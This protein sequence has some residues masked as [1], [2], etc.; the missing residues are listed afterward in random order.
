VENVNAPDDSFDVAS[1]TREQRNA[2]IHLPGR[3]RSLLP[4]RD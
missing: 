3:L 1:M 2:Q 4:V